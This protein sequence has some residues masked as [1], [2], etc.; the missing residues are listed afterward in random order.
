MHSKLTEPKSQ[1]V[2]FEPLFYYGKFVTSKSGTP[3]TS[4]KF[5][6]LEYFLFFTKHMKFSAKA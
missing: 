3:L 1:Y 6:I 5:L 4:T 2:V